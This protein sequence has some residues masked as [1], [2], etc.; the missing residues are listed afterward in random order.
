MKIKSFLLVPLVLMLCGYTRSGTYNTV[1]ITICSYTQATNTSIGTVANAGYSFIEI[2][3]NRS[4]PLDLGFYNLPAFY[5]CT[6]SVWSGTHN[7]PSSV[8]TPRGIGQG[9]YFNREAY[10]FNHTD[11]SPTN[12]LKYYKEVDHGDFLDRMYNG[13]FTGTHYLKTIAECNISNF[14]PSMFVREFY[15]KATGEDSLP[16][17]GTPTHLRHSISLLYGHRQEN[18]VFDKTEYFRYST[19]GTLYV[20]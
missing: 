13:D 8:G 16:L 19:N 12:C 14:T 1:G 3:N 17:Y 10:L 7:L 15:Y 20:Y 9:L 18:T 5:K 6:L 2:E 11:I 4:W